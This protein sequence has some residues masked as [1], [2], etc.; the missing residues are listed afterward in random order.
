M[1]AAQHPKQV[2]HLDDAFTFEPLGWAVRQ[3][4]AEFVNFLNN[5]LK[6][7]RGDGTYER[8]YAKWFQSDRWMKSVQ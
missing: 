2:V 5:Y 8:I 7:I 1:Y 6:Q 4:D 3:G